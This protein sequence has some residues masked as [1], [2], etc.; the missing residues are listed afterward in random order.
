MIVSVKTIPPLEGSLRL[1][2]TSIASGSEAVDGMSGVGG[3]AVTPCWGFLCDVEGG[4]VLG[5]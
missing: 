5:K 2:F 4:Q 3:L 1:G